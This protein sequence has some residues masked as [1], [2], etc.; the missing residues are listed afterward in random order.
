M[1][2]SFDHHLHVRLPAALGQLTQNNQLLDLGRVSGILQTAGPQAVAQAQGYVVFPA[3]FEQPV[4]MLEKGVF[5]AVALH[6]VE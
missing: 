2:R 4:E 3:Q 6:P 5:L 1:P